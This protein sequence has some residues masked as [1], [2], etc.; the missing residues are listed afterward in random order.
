MK[1]KLVLGS[2]FVILF[3]LVGCGGN[4]IVGTWVQYSDY[5]EKDKTVYEIDAKKHKMTI[6]E[7]SNGEIATSSLKQITVDEKDKTIKEKGT[8]LFTETIPY[9]VDHNQ[10][11][12]DSEVLYKEGSKEDKEAK[13]KAK[14]ER[15][16][17]EKKEKEEQLKEAHKKEDEEKLNEA[18]LSLEKRLN[19]DF[20][21]NYQGVWYSGEGI[22]MDSFMP[23]TTINKLTV[24]TKG[25]STQDVYIEVY[26]NKPRKV[27]KKESTNYT[28]SGIQLPSKHEYTEESESNSSFSYGSSN[29]DY[30]L[31]STIKEI[32]SLKTIDEFA[33]Y[34]ANHNIRELSFVY[35]SN[36]GNVDD[37]SI[38][39]NVN[40]LTH[41]ESTGSM[42]SNSTYKKEL[43]TGTLATDFN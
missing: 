1:Q 13:N 24:D 8:E 39:L 31:P 22:D 4:K 20:L 36:G 40:D 17:S 23:T 14:K 18:I 33:K 11:T 42:W 29:V 41:I 7:Y 19:N 12:L 16:K 43:P 25:M 38:I 6:S 30:E 32:E 15:I 2:L 10:L 5:S 28:F 34:E 35:Q 26:E 21:K 9:L 3:L 37:T 27:E